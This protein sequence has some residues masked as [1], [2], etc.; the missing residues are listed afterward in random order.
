MMYFS[1]ILRNMVNAVAIYMNNAISLTSFRL[2]T[3]GLFSMALMLRRSSRVETRVDFDS[4]T[5]LNI[6]IK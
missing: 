3:L 1:G 5:V 2:N 4:K 6:I